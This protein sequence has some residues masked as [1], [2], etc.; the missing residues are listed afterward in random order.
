MT[1]DE[2]PRGARRFRRDDVNDDGRFER[3]GRHGPD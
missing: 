1:P 3:E 2:P